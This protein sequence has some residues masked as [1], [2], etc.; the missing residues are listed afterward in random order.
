MVDA[1]AAAVV[2]N[3]ATTKDDVA[4]LIHLFKEPSAQR[5]WKT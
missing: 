2:V 4:R 5:Q 1:T 3:G